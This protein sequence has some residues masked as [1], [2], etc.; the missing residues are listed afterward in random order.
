MNKNCLLQLQ[1]ASYGTLKL[2]ITFDTS[3]MGCTVGQG[4]SN[5]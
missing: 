4:D 1:E 5:D 2:G 3:L